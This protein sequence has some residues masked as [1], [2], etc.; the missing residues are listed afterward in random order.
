[1]KTRR[2]STAQRS[3]LLFSAMIC[4]AIVQGA[5]AQAP[6]EENNT[7]T[8]SE[9]VGGLQEV[10]VTATHRAES[11]QDVP[12]SITAFDSGQLA[13]LG[14]QDFQDVGQAVPGLEFTRQGNT[15]IP[16]LRGVGTANAV[17]GNEPSVAVFV[18]DVY[19]P[20]GAASLAELTGLDH[21]EV[22]K[23]P[24]GTL[25][26]RNATGGVIQVFTKDPSPTPA[27]DVTAD[28]ATYNTTSG[29]VYAN[30]PLAESASANV[31]LYG[32]KQNTGWGTNFA[33]G[34]PVYTAYN[35]GGRAKLLVELGD[36]TRFLVTSF[37]DKT[38]TQEG[39]AYSVAAGEKSV[40]GFDHVGGFYDVNLDIDALARDLQWGVSAKV[41][42]DFEFAQ[43]LSISAYQAVQALNYSDV[44]LGPLPL[45]EIPVNSSD[46][47]ITQEFRLVSPGD[48]NFNWEGGLFYFHDDAGFDPIV[49]GGSAFPPGTQ[50]DTVQR[51]Q[52]YSGFAQA[53]VR[54]I[55]S[56]RL[57][58]GA[59]YTRDE[60]RLTAGGTL[61]GAA[62]TAANSPQEATFSKPTFR[63]SV[64][65]KLPDGTLLYVAFNT[66]FKS[67]TFNTN[68]FPGTPISPPVNP[69]TLNAYSLGLKGEYLNHTLRF[70]AEGFLYKYHNIQISE[71]L[72]GTT[73][74]LNAAAATIKGVDLDLTAAP[75]RNLTATASLEL[76]N[77]KYDR[78][79]NALFY[80]YNP[81]GGQIATSQDLSGYKTVQ[82]PPVSFNLSLNYTE[83]A[84]F[85]FLDYTLAY[86]LGGNFY[87][88]P[89]NGR[90]QPNSDFDRQPTTNIVN[91]S[92][93]WTSENAR[94]GVKLWVKN[95]LGQ[96]YYSDRTEQAFGA[97]T[98]PAA[99]RTAGLQLNLNL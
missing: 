46:N 93:K 74:V 61:E 34:S 26:G 48:P 9:V 21:L 85:G 18:D 64:D 25:F 41:T 4:V 73:E 29:S 1:M 45:A 59:R 51:T 44:D 67:G 49:Y 91:A 60:R 69:E 87:F 5:A 53:T 63:A 16:F 98:S 36:A 65:H 20:A 19:K 27:L 92:V 40:G 2:R 13:H 3:S 43:L 10:V 71:V 24:Q 12:I 50:G 42:H 77:G 11:G 83:S 31:S 33:T 78:Y 68:V 15:S 38:M 55:D 17:A 94:Y 6:P 89:D 35:Y 79:P 56:T 30:A 22:D 14:L 28:Y 39:A 8:P 80:V 95:A 99:P 66:G 86:Q 7:E 37:Y 76:L 82:T 32:G 70:N 90:G 52:S 57:T 88:D 58:L 84:L 75:V 72:D 62:V 81:A 54:V 96:K 23:G 47:A 97:L